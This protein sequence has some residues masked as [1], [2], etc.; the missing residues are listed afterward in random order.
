MRWG[1]TTIKKTAVS[2]DQHYYSKNVIWI[3]A[4]ANSIKRRHGFL[5]VYAIV[6]VVMLWD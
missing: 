6:V 1:K 4:G 5:Y 3:F 2:I